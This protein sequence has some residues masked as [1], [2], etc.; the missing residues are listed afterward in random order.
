MKTIEDFF[1]E[2]SSYHDYLA[3][4]SQKTIHTDEYE[5]RVQELYADWQQVK[6]SLQPFASEDVI[7]RCD[8]SFNTLLN[9]SRKSRSKV[10]NSVK[11]LR[12]IEDEYVSDIYPVI[13]G[14]EVGTGFVNSLVTDLEQIQSDKYHEYIEESIQC[15]QAGAYRGAVVLAWQGAMYALY[16]E[17]EN[18]SSPLHVVYQ[19]KFNKKIGYFSQ[20]FLGLSE[21]KG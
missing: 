17:L 15:I 6:V 4:K 7:S 21:N 13:S 16:V 1:D 19:Q 5:D 2:V 10:S 12:R 9:E 3:E 14:R 8:E 11:A 20:L 18:Q